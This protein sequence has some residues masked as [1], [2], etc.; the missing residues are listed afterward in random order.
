ME[1]IDSKFDDKK[2]IEGMA[3]IIVTAGICPLPDV[4][5]LQRT[6]NRL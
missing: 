4:T 3:E 5:P 6:I 2:F 1:E